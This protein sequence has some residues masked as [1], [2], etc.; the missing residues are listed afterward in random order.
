[1]LTQFDLSASVDAY[2]RAAHE[3]IAKAKIVLLPSP[4]T[5]SFS[6]KELSE[7]RIGQ[8][9]FS[10]PTGGK[11]EDQ[12]AEFIYVFRLSSSNTISSAKI[13]SAFNSARAFQES[14]AYKGKKNLCRPHPLSPESRALYVGRSYGPRERFKGHL[15]SSTSGTYAI[16]FAAWACSIDLP[17]DFD[18]YRFSGVGDRVIQV[19]EDGFWD[20][21][22]PMLGR[23]GEK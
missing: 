8:L 9:S 12:D 20:H 21:L 15:R 2:E 14:D 18:L 16:H 22:K 10:V 7:E 17:I 3:S 11:K 4:M 23:R 13:L 5:L 6:T 19:L 1:M